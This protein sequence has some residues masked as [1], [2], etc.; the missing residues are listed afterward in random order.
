MGDSYVDCVLCN[1]VDD[2]TQFATP[3]WLIDWQNR[4]KLKPALCMQV[5]VCIVQVILRLLE[6]TSAPSKAVRLS[7]VLHSKTYSD[8]SY[9]Y[10]LKLVTSLGNIYILYTHTFRLTQVPTPITCDY[11]L[12]YVHIYT[13]VN[14]VT[15][16]YGSDWL[17]TNLSIWWVGVVHTSTNPISFTPK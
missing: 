14:C 15:C 17:S 1:Y 11:I 2:P 3:G 12:A 9:I 16:S 10:S 4:V 13:P 7:F 8:L 6:K 5:L